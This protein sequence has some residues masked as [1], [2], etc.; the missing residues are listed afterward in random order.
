MKEFELKAE[1]TEL[2]DVNIFNV[3]WTVLEGQASFGELHEIM[4][5]LLVASEAF[6]EKGNRHELLG[7][8]EFA[9]DECVDRITAAPEKGVNRKK[10]NRKGNA[11]KY[12]Q[13]AR[14]TRLKKSDPDF[15]FM[16]VNPIV[17]SSTAASAS[18]HPRGGG[19]EIF[20][21]DEP[22]FQQDF[23]VCLPDMM[24]ELERILNSYP[25]AKELLSLYHQ[26]RRR[27]IPPT[28]LP[29]HDGRTMAQES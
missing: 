13:L 25:R 6:K 17:A 29:L 22:G 18:T 24:D 9:S 20:W 15:D 11:E 16:A 3:W 10:L 23:H 8:G 7:Q 4:L 12:Y 19:L 26:H 14:A 27:Y 1:D 5:A 21:E 2:L 28:S